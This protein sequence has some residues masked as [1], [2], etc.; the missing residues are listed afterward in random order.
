M[1]QFG[2]QFQALCVLLAVRL[3]FWKAEQIL[4][5]F[6]WNQVD[7]PENRYSVLSMTQD[8]AEKKFLRM[9]FVD[10]EAR[11]FRKAAV[12]MTVAQLLFFPLTVAGAYRDDGCVK[13]QPELLPRLKPVSSYA[14]V[15]CCFYNATPNLIPPTP[16]RYGSVGSTTSI[17]K[18]S[19]ETQSCFSG[20][21]MPLNGTCFPR[22][23]TYAEAV[24]TCG[25]H[26]LRL[27][28][29]KEVEAGK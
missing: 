16:D 13:C 28:K 11:P 21:T 22:A 5:T 14:T 7:D 2:E 3:L 4:A 23:A 26:G 19:N 9:I 8:Q 10:E 25:Q 20:P 18:A 15:R 12:L 29:I 6:V 27:C 17:M 24:Q 1:N